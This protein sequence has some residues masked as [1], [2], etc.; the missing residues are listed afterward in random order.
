MR[1]KILPLVLTFALALSPVS[2]AFASA[3]LSPDPVSSESEESMSEEISADEA[4]TQ[5]L[6][7]SFAEPT[8][9]TEIET[10]EVVSETKDEFSSE[11]FIFRKSGEGEAALTGLTGAGRELTVPK[12]VAFDEETLLVTSI[13]EGALSGE[14]IEKIK[15]PAAIRDF[16]A[17]ELPS[18]AAVETAEDSEVYTAV[19]GVLFKKDEEGKSTL[20]LYPSAKEG[21][22]YVIP[23]ETAAVSEHAFS[24][25]A[26]LDTIVIGTDL[27][28]VEAGAFSN[29]KENARIAFLREDAEIDLEKGAFTFSENAGS[30]LYF[31]NADVLGGILEKSPEF[32]EVEKKEESDGD[33]VDESVDEYV[34]ESLNAAELVGEAAAE[35]S[36]DESAEESPAEE[37]LDESAEE[38]AAESEVESLDESAEESIAES[39]EETVNETVSEA[40]AF[41]FNADGIPE[42]ILALI[43][44][45]EL[46]VEETPEM[47]AAGKDAKI[48]RGYYEIVNGFRTNRLMSAENGSVKT[49]D[50]GAPIGSTYE[51]VP[52]GGEK[53]AFINFETGNAATLQRTPP[54]NYVY[55]NDAAYTG[56]ETQKWYIR[57][58]D[59]E[60]GTVEI[61][62]VL[63]DKMRLEIKNAL[64]AIGTP[65]MLYTANGTGAQSWKI[66]KVENVTVSLTDGIYTIATC[67]NKNV[68]VETAN[69]SMSS[70]A[71][72]QLGNN[73]NGRYQQFKLISLG[74]GNYYKLE[75]LRSHMVWDVAGGR[76]YSGANIQ[77]YAW[78]GTGAQIFK[79]IETVENGEKLYQFIGKASGLAVDYAGA[80][81]KAGTNVRLY[82]PNGSEGQKWILTKQA[83]ETVLGTDAK[84]SSGYYKIYSPLSSSFAVGIISATAQDGLSAVMCSADQ[85]DGSVFQI[86]PTSGGRYKIVVAGTGKVL[87]FV[88]DYADNLIDIVQRSANGKS[89]QEWYI[90]KKSA[91]DT[92]YVFVSA[93]NPRVVMDLSGGLANNGRN[94]RFYNSNGTP[95]QT[96]RL[97][98][99]AD[100]NS[101]VLPNGVYSIANM[102]KT[103]MVMA[104]S[105]SSTSNGGNIVISSK[106]GTAPNQLFRVEAY[107]SSGNEYKITNLW[108]GLSLD[109]AGG[110]KASGA[111]LQQYSWNN[112]TAQRF[113][114]IQV[115]GGSNPVYKIIGTGSGNAID[116][117]SGKTNEG[118]NVQMYAYNGSGAQ[119]W[120]FNKVSVVNTVVTGTF[121]N[122]VSKVNS[123]YKIGW[124]VNGTGV[125]A[126]KDK[127]SVSQAFRIETVSSGVYRVYNPGSGKYLT[128][129]G[130]GVKFADWGNTSSQKWKFQG[131]GDSD[132][133]FYI[134]NAANG[135]YLTTVNNMY[136]GSGAWLSDASATNNRKFVI[137]PAVIQ[138]GWVEINGQWR[139]YK[140]DGTFP[141]DTF[142][143]N[144][145]YYFNSQG[146]AGTGW[147][148]YGGFYYYYKGKDG[149]EMSDARP[150]LSALFGTKT[151]WNGYNC[152][153]CSYH[154]SVD[155]AYPC[156]ITVYTTYPGTS[157]WNLPVMSF[158]CSPGTTQSNGMSSTIYGDRRVGDK[159]RWQEL[160]GPSYGQYA[161]VIETYTYVAG[162]DGQIIDWTNTGQY[163][164]SVACGQP[165]EENLDPGT[166]NLLGTRQS[167]GCVRVPVRY[168]YWIYSFTERNQGIGVGENLVRPLNTLKLPRAVTAVDPTD[169]KYTG[170]WG[171]LD[172]QNYQFWQGQ[173]LN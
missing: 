67:K 27:E 136:D 37:S 144:G 126:Q 103:S 114:I 98:K 45:E 113:K 3:E 35:E 13:E 131:T 125:T 30:V 155:T 18:L 118:T 171:Y 79:V 68:V 106:S 20:V 169:P 143:E 76:T 78:N 90:R 120:Q 141:V 33:S 149:R 4:V 57:T 82:T 119:L 128:A 40:P 172:N 66:R 58:L 52:L 137:K 130:T 123:G 111:N 46:E 168:A 112:S 156:Q 151:S 139:Y 51:I 24:K 94:V 81:A 138:S 154:L 83:D 85:M 70:S 160:M 158:L 145:K 16:G 170:N 69:G 132:Y 162:S 49:A 42:D 127:K 167:H 11:S 91:S 50:I 164:H 77:Q 152:P 14:G 142:Y 104:V 165:N 109:V 105:G 56:A 135:K 129:D 72:I 2:E 34:E 53:Y 36:L 32:A 38:S 71:N 28:K 12:E 25:T 159:S 134:V 54:A 1:K 65:L 121:V 157:G 93:D 39:V 41:T 100:P 102:N 87:T 19:D 31:V 47:V 88:G 153:N 22:D 161:T 9:N 133:S 63:D 173:Y 163:I 84:I 116:V 107:G 6:E 7:E 8:E 55:I 122:F 92:N 97:E 5:I 44:T 48:T 99:V 59:A 75:N 89:N 60:A 10:P 124:Q 21:K 108:S 80:M 73:S 166:Y 101:H 61:I 140:S 62:P 96:W 64:S 43:E 110:R 86:T 150:Y 74:Y 15:L 147:A 146:Y 23:E 26:N 115:R 148:R 29:M 117:A 17:Q 95:A